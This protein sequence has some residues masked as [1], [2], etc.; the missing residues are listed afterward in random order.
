MKLT[1]QMKPDFI[2]QPGQVNPASHHF[3]R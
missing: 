2:D 3:T 1:S